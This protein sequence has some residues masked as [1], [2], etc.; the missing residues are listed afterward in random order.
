VRVSPRNIERTR[1]RMLAV[2]RVCIWTTFLWR[3]ALPSL[4]TRLSVEIAV[5]LLPGGALR[6]EASQRR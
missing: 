1:A 2:G 6:E 3:A 5:R 4:R